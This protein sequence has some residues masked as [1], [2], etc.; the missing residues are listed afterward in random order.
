M[1][2]VKPAKSAAPDR[3]ASA[4]VSASVP[5]LIARAAAGYSD[6]PQEAAGLLL[7]AARQA[8]RA[9]A[10]DEDAKAA[11]CRL[12]KARGNDDLESAYWSLE[13]FE[14]L[15]DQVFAD[16]QDLRV[17]EQHFGILGDLL[18]MLEL[19]GTDG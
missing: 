8:V 10:P 9:V 18:E 16:Y 3:A 2:A 15:Y 14:E 17:W 12:S 19:E 5:V 11:V 1:T 4:P 13:V 6:R 7:A